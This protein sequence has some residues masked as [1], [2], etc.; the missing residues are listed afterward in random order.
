MK[1]LVVAAIPAF[2]GLFL[3]AILDLEK[4]VLFA[5][6][7]AIVFPASLVKPF[8]TNVDAADILLL[9][10]LMAW[11]VTNALRQSPDPWIRGNSMVLPAGVFLAVNAASAAWSIK[12]RSTIIF[13]VQLTE[14]IVLFPIIFATIPRSISRLR[15]CLVTFLVLTTGEGIATLYQYASHPSSHAAGTY[16]PGLGKNGLGS[17][18]AAG[19]VIACALWFGSGKTG[20]Y[21]LVPAI[22]I[23]L[24]STI[25][26]ESRGSI[27][28]AGVGVLVVAFL[29]GRRRMLAVALGVSLALLYVVVIAPAESHKAASGGYDSSL[30]RH[31]SWRYAIK[32]I[33]HQPWIGTGART[34]YEYLPPPIGGAI[35]D[36]NN[37]FLLTWAELGIP[38]MVALGFLLFRFAQLLVRSRRLPDEAATLAVGCGAAAISFLVHY[39]VDISWV[40]G[41]TTLEFAMIG[42]MLAANRLAATAT[43]TYVPVNFV[44]G[45]QWSTDPVP[46]LEVTA[47]V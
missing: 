15:Q 28:G 1:V 22:M 43:T 21:W 40:R 35:P 8:G 20:R 36:P 31:I 44:D 9:M 37:L 42:L 47:G 16:L 12:P 3:W 6:F 4:F 25:A 19:L 46:A 45:R 33:K 39:Q 13:A 7:G 27:L 41:E 2:V 30:V 26:T 24:G 17:F 14:L 34:Y 11:V 23:L 38:G 32:E 5:V 29:L 10:A 18:L